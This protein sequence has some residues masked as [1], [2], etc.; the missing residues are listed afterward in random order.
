M[1]PPKETAIM[2]GGRRY[3][4]VMALLVGWGLGVNPVRAE[5]QSLP[6]FRS[7]AGAFLASHNHNFFVESELRLPIMREGPVGVYYLHQESTPFLDIPSGPQAEL[8]YERESAQVDFVVNPNLRVILVGGYDT[9]HLEDRT[10]FFSAFPLGG[11]LGSALQPGTQRLRWYVLGGGYTGRHNLNSSWWTDLYGS[12]RLYEFLYDRYLG[13]DYR[14]SVNVAARVES[15]NNGDRFR[16]LYRIGPELELLTANGNRANLALDWYH[17]DSNPFYGAHENGLVIGLNVVSSRDD[18]YV[19]DARD[20][21]EPGW[22]P[23]IWGDYDVG[24]GGNIRTERFT[25]NV[26]VADFEI[27]SQRITPFVWY[28]S[29]QEYRAGDYDNMNY[30]VTLGLQTPIGLESPVSQGQPLV[31]GLDFLH[32]S[33]HSLNPSSARVAADGEASPIGPLVP[34]G[35]VN[36]L[37]RLRLQTLGWDLP[38]RDPHMYDRKTHWLNYVDW[39]LTAGHTATSS[40]ERGSFSGQIGL[41]WDIATVLGYVAYVQGLGSIGNETPDW[42]G[43]IGVRRPAV[44][45]F[46]R[47]ESYGVTHSI[48]H[49]DIF[50]LGIGV[51]L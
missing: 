28:E 46:G 35:S 34:K 16:G 31:A 3:L 12:C 26:E 43:E 18:K 23:L 20:K 51:N 13:S 2:V 50:V 40:R 36:I 4:A 1:F 22:L 15:S 42:R 37:P 27:A 30:S 47:A 11:G 45:V 24:F 8:L 29:H 49:G 14:A 21:R 7:F 44:K 6:T 17:N 5:D 25:M 19:F 38:Y 41:N 9:L 33:D 32:R 48:V 10:G 39:R